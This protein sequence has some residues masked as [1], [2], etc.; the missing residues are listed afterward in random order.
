MKTDNDESIYNGNDIPYTDNEK[1]VNDNIK[2]H[3]NT[4][5]CA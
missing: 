5:L 3:N 4:Y 2:L 1:P